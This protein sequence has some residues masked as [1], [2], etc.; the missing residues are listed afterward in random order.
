MVQFVQQLINGVSLGCIYA[1][2]ALGY[3]M[4]YGIVR[5]INFAHGDVYMVGAYIGYTV[6]GAMGPQFIPALLTAMA[7]AAVLGIVIEKLAYRPLRYAP[8]IASLTTA[9]GVS[10][11]LQNW[12]RKFISP[13]FLAF[14]DLINRITWE[15]GGLTLSN[16][17][18]IVPIVAILLVVVLQ[19]VVLKTKPGKAMRAV[20][21]DK[22]CAQLMGVDVDRVI[23]LTFA[24]GSAL[25]AAGGV[26]VGIA[27]PRIDP[28]MGQMA[29]LKAFVAAV[30]GGIGIIPGAALGGLFMG[31]AEVMAVH[32][33]NSAF[34]DAIAFVILIFVLLIKPSGLLGKHASEKV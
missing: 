20:S 13:N 8:R 22:D 21:L 12:V 24:L 33:I 31:L 3:T 27:Y 29:G 32:F 15:I 2:I 7:G 6:A 28:Y 16:V 30:L 11:F 26:L 34:K 9:I 4:V 10:L 17:Q 25:A 18:V 19:W 5:L 1:L 14:P 23:S